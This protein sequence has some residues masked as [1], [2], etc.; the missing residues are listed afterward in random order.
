M[1]IRKIT[2]G[3]Q[4][5]FSSRPSGKIFCSDCNEK[6]AVAELDLPILVVGE[7]E[8][9]NIKDKEDVMK[10]ESNPIA[11]DIC[12]EREQSY[13]DFKLNMKALT[14]SIEAMVSQA[15]QQE[16]QLPDNFGALVM[17]NVKILRE[18]FN[19]KDDNSIDHYN[20]LKVSEE[21]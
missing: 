11:E 17:C 1:K 12:K 5:S 19:H 21:L 16:V 18:C 14:R 6:L 4:Y 13:G 7:G 8:Y 15:T 2:C 3:H 9:N 10:L 20:Y